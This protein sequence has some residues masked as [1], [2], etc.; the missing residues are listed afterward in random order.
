MKFSAVVIALAASV[1]AT[2]SATNKMLEAKFFDHVAKYGLEFEDGAEFARRM[3]IFA[4]NDRVI[5]ES[6]AQNLTYT[7]GHNAFSHMTNDEFQVHFNLGT[8]ITPKA[9]G[10]SIHRADKLNAATDVDWVAGGA[11]TGVKDQ[12]S[13]GSCWAFSSTGGLEGAYAVANNKDVSTWDGLSEQQLVSCDTTDAGCNGG[14]M[15]TAFEWVMGNGGLCE[16][17]D[18]AYTSGGG[19]TGTCVSGC[20]PY[21]GTTPS[22]YTD[23]EESEEALMS[24]VAQ[25][26]VSVAIQANQL[27][28]QLYS[29]GVLTGR[30][31]TSL[32]HG[33]LAAGYGT[34]TDGTDYWKVKNSWGSSWG[35]DGYILIERGNSQ[36]GGQCGILMSASYPTL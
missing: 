25:Q 36:T 11:V 15:D 32:D 35:M 3:E 7:L 26:P 22:G 17:S 2:A 4:E 34:Y 9:K 13:C 28:F 5:E 23:V 6:N 8:P 30:C 10:T 20:S 16:E 31:G 14:L 19:T 1:L 18:Y 29:S 33:V 21:A 27:S 12:G 24:A